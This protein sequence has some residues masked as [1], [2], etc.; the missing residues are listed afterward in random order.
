MLM[1]LACLCVYY[2]YSQEQTG[3]EGWCQEAKGDV[4]K[5]NKTNIYNKNYT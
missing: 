4:I 5:K 2:S 1:Q 3:D